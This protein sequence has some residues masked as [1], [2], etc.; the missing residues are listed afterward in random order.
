MME[1]ITSE[2][3]KD[4]SYKIIKREPL[5]EAEEAKILYEDR[6]KA[7]RDIASMMGG[8]RKEE[9]LEI[10]RNAVEMGLD[11]N[12]IIKLTGLSREEIESL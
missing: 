11:V 12:L 7:R 4:G 6:E 1:Q 2:K 9:R 10:A 8:A 5:S 3:Q